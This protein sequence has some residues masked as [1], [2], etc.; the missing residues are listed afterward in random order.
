MLKLASL[1]ITNYLYETWE[2]P[3]MAKEQL[4][5]MFLSSIFVMPIHET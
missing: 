1:K 3:V 4:Y 2:F 5:M